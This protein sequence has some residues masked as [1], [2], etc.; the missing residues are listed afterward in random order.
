MLENLEASSLSPK[1]IDDAAGQ[2]PDAAA[3]VDSQ[4]KAQGTETDVDAQ[5]IS[6]DAESDQFTVKSS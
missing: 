1:S 6:F 2:S 5:K 3:E 4:T